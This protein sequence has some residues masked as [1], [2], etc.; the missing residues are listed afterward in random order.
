MGRSRKARRKAERARARRGVERRGLSVGTRLAITAGGV[1]AIVAGVALLVSG[2]PS[3]EA[4]LSRVAGILI[5]LGI[6]GIV[7]AAIGRL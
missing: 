5:L 7:A 4:R 3:T 6:V 2:T 1:V